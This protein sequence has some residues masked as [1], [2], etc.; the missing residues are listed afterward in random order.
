MTRYS[1]EKYINTKVA[2]GFILLLVVAVLS[3]GVNYFGVVRYMQVDKKEDFLGQRLMVLNELMFRMQEADGAARLYSLTGD[4]KD[5][6][7]YQDRTD[8]VLSTLGR[9]ELFFPDSSFQAEVDTIRDLFFQKKEQ[10][11][12][13]IELSIINRYR[14]RYGEVLS[15]LPDS[16]NYQISQITYSSLHVDSTNNKMDSLPEQN[17][18]FFGRIA[19]MLTGKEEDPPP[20]KSPEIKQRVDSSLIIRKRKDPALEEVKTQLQKLDKQDKRFAMI[21]LNREKKLVEVAN[22]LTNT[23]RQ[24]VKYLE[25]QALRESATRQQEMSQMREDLL[26]RLVFLGI[27]ALLII[28]GFVLWIG[29]DL[30]KS[31]QLKNQLVNSREKIESLMKVKERFLA[32]MSHEIRT[33]LTSI[34]GFSELQKE[35][36]PSAEVI[37][38]SA[39]HLL[40]L[41]NDVL[42]IS[43]LEAG[44]LTFHKEHINPR[45]L[46]QEVWQTFR[47]KANEKNLEFTYSVDENLPAFTADKT[48]L[49]QVLFNLI[50]NAIKFT[51][52]GEVR[53]GVSKD[54]DHILFEVIDTGCGIPENRIDHIFEEFSQMNE[55][56]ATPRHGSGLGLSISKKLVEAM[57][58]EIRGKS[59]EGEG[60]MFWFTI[61]YM[62]SHAEPGD[63]KQSTAN[64]DGKYILVVDDDPL[65]GRLLE[66]FLKHRSHIMTSESPDEALLLMHRHQFDLIVTDFRMPGINGISFIE[67]VRSRHNGPILILSAGISNENLRQLEHFENVYRMTK[68]FSREDL[69]NKLQWLLSPQNPHSFKKSASEETFSS[70]LTDLSGV[71]AF[72]GDDKDFFNSV[73]SAFI[74]DTEENIETLS[75]LIKN[76]DQAQ[77]SEKA[78]KMLTGF[79]Q[80]GISEGIEIL[81][82]IE[83]TAPNSYNQREIKKSLKRLKELWQQVKNELQ[84]QLGAKGQ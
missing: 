55:T 57:G 80:F 52:K 26:K 71:Y 56:P 8:S 28:L 76:R 29:R 77:I 59:K 40:A 21:V 42:D 69:E 27:S 5:R 60:S 6:Q 10:T 39:V 68:P 14:R 73:V 22:K 31:K 38:N 62:E 3:F 25:N 4:K 15:I 75:L 2:A 50:S 44:K 67:K 1:P 83:T 43:S 34:I 61:P 13:L 64:I 84:K 11:D 66:G 32:N 74:Q 46:M 36:D 49:R 53:I 35:K 12:Q 24:I 33:P 17:K 18:S 20:P 37:H 81:K 54:K 70:S 51:D 30:R 45:E 7:A 23:I 63:I 19:S 82:K 16:I 48:R 65:V 78:H 72:T 9:L 47:H 58:G 79:R 41:V